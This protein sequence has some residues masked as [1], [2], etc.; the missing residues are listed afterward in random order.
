MAKRKKS[1]GQPK[2]PIPPPPPTQPCTAIVC[3]ENIGLLHLLHDIQGTPSRNAVPHLDDTEQGR[4]LSLARERSLCGALAF[5]AS[6]DDNPNHVP[7]VCVEEVPAASSLRIRVAMN[8]DKPTDCNAVLAVIKTGFEGVFRILSRID[9][10]NGTC[11]FIYVEG[12][13]FFSAKSESSIRLTPDGALG[14]YQTRTCSF[15]CG[16]CHVF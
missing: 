12:S 2:T 7:A 13:L 3:A 5:L 1:S 9:D 16:S 4:G 15:H 6:I 11:I 8:K 10:D 14:R